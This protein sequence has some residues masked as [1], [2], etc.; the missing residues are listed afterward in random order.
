MNSTNEPTRGFATADSSP[1]VVQGCDDGFGRNGRRPKPIE[2]A[3]S[4]VVQVDGREPAGITWSH[5]TPSRGLYLLKAASRA[6]EATGDGR[7][8][9]RDVHPLASPTL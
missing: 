9:A 8:G 2:P 1:V 3:G 5:S 7:E 6:G 4:V